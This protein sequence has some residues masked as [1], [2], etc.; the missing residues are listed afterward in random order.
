MNTDNK[1]NP[2]PTDQSDSTLENQENQ[3]P[4][5]ETTTEHGDKQNGQSLDQNTQSD[6]NDLNIQQSE[7]AETTD[8]NRERERAKYA[9]LES[10]VAKYSKSTKEYEST[11]SE[12]NSTFAKSPKAYE[13]F[14]EAYKL[15]YGVDLGPHEERFGQNRTPSQQTNQ[16]PT[17]T[18]QVFDKDQLFEEFR[19]RES[20][21][22]D[23]HDFA[24]THE[25]FKIDLSEAEEIRAEK[26][27]KFSTINKWANDLM[28]EN[29]KL[30]YRDALEE[31]YLSRPENRDKLL[32]ERET[33]TENAVRATVN[34]SHVSAT[35]GTTGTSSK[36]NADGEL[37]PYEQQLV[38]RL[39]VPKD[40][41]LERKRKSNF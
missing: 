25:E 33:M 20:L 12:L 36:S 27:R 5:L 15:E 39:G 4:L 26:S 3:T 18:D 8:P 29:P 2:T 9:K 11:F 19:Q 6:Q 41:Y 31:A 16:T 38:K 35:S 10:D 34:A 1:G 7:T 40:K 13:E 22:R 14:R 37:D 30:S 21:N 32:Q 28:A 23:I 24:Q 17:N